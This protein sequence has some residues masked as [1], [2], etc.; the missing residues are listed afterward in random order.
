MTSTGRVVHVSKAGVEARVII[1]ESMLADENILNEIA[2][3][4][5]LPRKAMTSAA[6]TLNRV[7]NFYGV[8]VD[9]DTNAVEGAKVEAKVTVMDGV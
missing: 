1:P 4:K 5:E 3:P 8:T 7:L 2:F 9:E 6:S